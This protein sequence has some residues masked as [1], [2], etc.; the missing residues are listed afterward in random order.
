MTWNEFLPMSM[1]IV[2]TIGV[3]LLDMAVLLR[4]PS[5]VT[6]WQ[7]HGRTIRLSN[8]DVR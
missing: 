8:F 3:D 7:W 2:T 5:S 6:R 1:P 4:N